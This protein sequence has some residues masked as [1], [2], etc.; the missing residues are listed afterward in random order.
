MNIIGHKYIFLTFSATLVAA[1]FFAILFW[2]LKPGIDFSG[3]SLLE[4]EYSKNLPPTEEIKKILSDF[5]I[6]NV[7]LQPSG[8]RSFLMR[9]PHVDEA[10]HQQIL[11][12]LQISAG[13]DNLLTEKQFTT[14]GPTIGAELKRRALEAL[15]LASLGI[16]IY[17]AWAFRNVSKPMS[18]WKYGV[19]AVVVAFMHDVPIPAGVFAVLGYYKNVEVDTL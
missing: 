15:A 2:G 16:I 7:I 18:S 6:D 14:I 19:V 12:A 8:E 13:Q 3:G 11:G 1:S 9:F 4:A 5:N 10:T 17:L